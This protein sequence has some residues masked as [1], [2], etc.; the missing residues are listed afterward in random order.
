MNTTVEE[1]LTQANECY[2]NGHFEKSIENFASVLDAP[3]VN[4]PAILSNMS[5]VSLAAG[6]VENAL[7][8]ANEALLLEPNFA[9]AHYNLAKAL[10]KQNNF[11]GA[12]QHYD[13]ATINNAGFFDAYYNKANLLSELERYEESLSDYEKA[14]TCEPLNDK[15][16][17]NM[18]IA[19]TKLGLDDRA[20]ALYAKALELNPTSENIWLNIALALQ[21][22]KE[23]GQAKVCLNNAININPDFAEAKW[24]LALLCLT[25]KEFEQGWKLYEYRFDDTL[26]E[27]LALPE[28]KKPKASVPNKNK[29]VFV[30]NEQG[31]GD[32]VMLCRFLP[33]L[34]QKYAKVLYQPP[35]ELSRL[36]RHSSTIS[37]EIEMVEQI[38]EDDFDEFVPIGSLPLLL[39]IKNEDV[40]L[41]SSY[42]EAPQSGKFDFISNDKQLKVGLVWQ[43]SV[44]IQRLDKKR[45]ISLGE[46]KGLFEMQNISFYALQKGYG[47][48]QVKEFGFEDKIKILSDDFQDFADTAEAIGKLDIVI[49]VDTSVAHVSAALGKPTWILIDANNCFRWGL[50]SEN[51]Y[52]Y[53][54][55][56]LFRQERKNI[57]NNVIEKI[58]QELKNMM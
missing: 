14:I 44:H 37:K 19:C 38:N 27:R 36:I 25:L 15:A 16:Y 13:N 42:L 6:E 26:R 30:T 39:N 9:E 32:A 11:L 21:S 4:K 35:K 40:P 33:L 54:S 1:A 53:D 18:A 12:L 50:S 22:N 17:V 3:N 52:W 46:F 24:S 56:R 57:W 5:V 43:G 20:F 55:V 10:Y 31:F 28:I 34:A 2:Q 41:R 47:I 58:T 7:K 8:Y 48:E 51:S 29:T 49:T 45:S 23:Y